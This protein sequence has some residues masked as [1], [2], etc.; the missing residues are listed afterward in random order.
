MV[1]LGR[2]K[3]E[4]EKACDGGNTG[5]EVEE[6]GHQPLEA[7]RARKQT[8]SLQ[9][10]LAPGVSPVRAFRLLSS[11]AERESMCAVLSY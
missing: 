11:V 6:R 4:W 10:E 3:T 9:R 1:L 2:G 8:Q 5:H 7:K